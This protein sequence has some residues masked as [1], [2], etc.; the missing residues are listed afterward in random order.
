MRSRE[1]RYQGLGAGL[2][3]IDVLREHFGI[4]SHK[5]VLLVVLRRVYN[6][7]L[8]TVYGLLGESGSE[9]KSAW[10]L[11]NKHHRKAAAGLR[12]CRWLGQWWLT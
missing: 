9:E 6:G 2:D 7:V 5:K 11:L 3:S 4:I 8:L 12:Q 1:S 10:M